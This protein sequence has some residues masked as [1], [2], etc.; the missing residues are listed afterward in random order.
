YAEK[1]Y[2]F[3]VRCIKDNDT[4]PT[5]STDTVTEIT[6]NSAVCGGNISF[7]G[8][9][10]ITARGICWSNNPNP[11]ILNNKVEEN[12]DKVTFISLMTGLMADS[13]Y[14]VRAYATNNVGT[15]YG[16]Q[17]SFRTLK[18]SEQTVT[19]IDGNTYHTVKIG[20]QTWMVENLKTTKFNDGSTIPLV[21]DGYEWSN[22]TTPGYCW[23]SNI[24]LDSKDTYGAL[25]N[26]YTVNTGKLAPI[27]W[28]VP[29]QSEIDTLANHL[30]GYPLAGSLL[31]ESGN[32]HWYAGNSDATNSSG[33]TALPGGYRSSITGDYH[34]SG[35]WG[36]FWS[37]TEVNDKGGRYIL[38][39]TS[40]AF[41]YN[42]DGKK[43]GFSVRCI[44]DND[45][46]P[47]LSTDTVTEITNNSAVCKGNITLDGGTGITARGA[48]WSTTENPTIADNKTTDNVGMGVF[49]SSITGLSSDT[50]YYVR[51]YA[52]NSVGT[53]YGEQLSFKTLD[54]TYG[55]VLYLPLNGNTNDSSSYANNGINHGALAT[56]DRFGNSG[57]AMYFDGNSYIDVPGT[58]ELDLTADKSVSCWI[59]IPS[60]E[61][62]N[63]Y[64]TIILKDEPVQG[65]TYSIQLTDHV[66]YDLDRF[67]LDYFFASDNTNYQIH[68]KQL[69]TDY[70]DKWIHV[71][72]TY[73]TA[74]GDSKIYFNG[75]LSDSIHIG[76]VISN[77]SNLDLYIGGTG[78]SKYRYEQTFFKG[79]IDDVKIYNRVLSAIEVRQLYE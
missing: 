5:L 42:S 61:T 33:F 45:T 2:G 31:K 73:D 72:G 64:P 11:T 19:D 37:S 22:L 75:I 32:T 77:S 68:T 23:Y 14:Y 34:N 78:T 28:H 57:K 39:N 9:T 10:L 54:S 6:N 27:G 53:A 55:L 30:G 62:Q 17:V 4:I 52:T 21:S 7:D 63:W 47:T 38:S 76:K 20:T 15:A 66:G 67:K 40:S 71:V 41:E 43:C 51:A 13:T 16:E 26:W 1:T 69:Y 35:M 44:K 58:R 46:I 59:Y 79:A 70:K 24:L 65:T 49:S 60:S 25:Y 29:T 3:S 48:C 74:S 18:T 8:G 36:V 50:T 56:A 12:S